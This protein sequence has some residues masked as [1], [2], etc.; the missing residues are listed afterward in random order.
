MAK[1]RMLSIEVVETDLFYMLPP[2]SQILYLHINLNADDDGFVGNVN[3]LVRAV[4]VE[5]KY[6]R[7][8]V[9]R[10]YLIEFDSGVVAVAHWR[11]HNRVRCDR[12]T[13]TRYTKELSL[14]TLGEDMIY[15]KAF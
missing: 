1:R 11:V 8:L 13:P 5:R 10:G 12:H 3:N 4:G 14:L 15:T 6:F 7:L 2:S 9:E